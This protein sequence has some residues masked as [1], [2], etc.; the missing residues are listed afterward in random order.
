MTITVTRP[1]ALLH[2]SGR[3]IKNLLGAVLPHL[4][5][6]G[7]DAEELPDLTRLHVE[8]HA[9]ELRLI[10][11]DRYT[12]AVTRTALTS[13]T[14]DFALAIPGQDAKRLAEGLKG[15]ADVTL[16][17]EIDRL[18]VSEGDHRTVILGHDSDLQWRKVLARF[19]T[20]TATPADPILINADYLAR[21]APARRL[22][23]GAPMAIRMH[24]EHKKAIVATLGEHFL[25]LIMPI[26][27]TGEAP[28]PNPLDGWFDLLDEEP[29]D[30]AL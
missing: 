26:L 22:D 5:T 30:G 1:S 25:A 20:P 18:I 11:S 6:D 27:R 4:A 24:G 14:E 7:P 28:Q 10:C 16:S 13:A 9:G 3:D 19:L 23:E 8:I 2:A 15:R 17:F 21:L 12:M 29:Q